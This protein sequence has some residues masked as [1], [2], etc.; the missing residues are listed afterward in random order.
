MLVVESAGDV[1]GYN[2]MAPLFSIVNT[3]MIF[4]KFSRRLGQIRCLF[5]N[6]VTLSSQNCLRF[7]P[8]QPVRCRRTISNCW[9]SKRFLHEIWC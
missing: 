8:Q 5:V 4:S 7:I 9:T 3:Y 2:I 6:G 1:V